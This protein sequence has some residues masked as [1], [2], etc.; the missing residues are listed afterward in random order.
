MGITTS[1][2]KRINVAF[3]ESVLGMPESV[4]SARKRKA[5]AAEAAEEALRKERQL[6]AIQ[7]SSGAW[8]DEIIPI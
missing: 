3:P 6:T 4:M 8:S 7:E 5:F 1:T 2:K